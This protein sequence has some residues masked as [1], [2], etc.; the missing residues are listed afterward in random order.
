MEFQGAGFGKGDYQFWVEAATVAG[1]ATVIFFGTISVNKILRQK[2][3]KK[4]Q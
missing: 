4:D 1:Q 3:F 2:V